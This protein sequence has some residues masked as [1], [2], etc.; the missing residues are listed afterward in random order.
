MSAKP[1]I[2][3]DSSDWVGVSV[4]QVASSGLRKHCLLLR[5]L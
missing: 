5:I 3:H 1:A 4:S 2:R